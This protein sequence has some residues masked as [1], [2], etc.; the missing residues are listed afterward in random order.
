[1]L[2]EI[3][4]DAKTRM[5]KTIDALR[6]E[7]SHLRTGKATPSLLD[8]VMVDAYG[9]KMPLN[10]LATIG[11]PEA[12]LLT[13]QPFDASQLGAI[14]KAI[15]A[16]DLGIT[17]N[18]DGNLI[19]LPIPALNEERRREDG[20]DQHEEYSCAE[21]EPEV[22]NVVLQNGVGEGGGNEGEKEHGHVFTRYAHVRQ[23]EPDEHDRQYGE[24]AQDQSRCD[25]A[26]FYPLR[27]IGYDVGADEQ[28]DAR[29]HVK[30]P[31]DRC[32]TVEKDDRTS[33]HSR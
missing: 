9:Q 23:K 24:N 25:N 15:L 13:V 29:E 31:V 22:E 4:N 17:P 21:N 2:D 27:G 1:M 14:E 12:R 32:D 6:R 30:K 18:N 5:E 20:G 3:Q 28:D 8:D 26:E 19:R 7:L 10:Q 33:F 11:A 16:S